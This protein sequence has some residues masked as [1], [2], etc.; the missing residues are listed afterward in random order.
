METATC[1]AV[2]RVAQYMTVFLG[3][4]TNSQEHTA[5]CRAIRPFC[6]TFLCT[7]PNGAG[8]YNSSF[9]PCNNPIGFSIDVVDHL[10]NISLN[11]TRYE[12]GMFATTPYSSS[13]LTL[14]QL[15]PGMVGF[16]VSIEL[17]IPTHRY[18]N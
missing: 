10:A 16:A 12:S 9:L 3:N 11:T 5:S 8:F 4:L 1:R 15:G 17:R 14:D 6:N 18:I 2:D 13:E 7:L